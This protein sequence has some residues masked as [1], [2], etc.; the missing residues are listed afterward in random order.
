ML[1]KK[2]ALSERF[3]FRII[4]SLT[5]PLGYNKQF[6]TLQ[7][8]SG[9]IFSLFPVLHWK[10]ISLFI[11]SSPWFQWKYMKMTFLKCLHIWYGQHSRLGMLQDVA[12]DYI[13]FLQLPGRL[14]EP[15]ALGITG[16]F[17]WHHLFSPPRQMSSCISAPTPT[18]RHW[19]PETRV[20][21][22]SFYLFLPPEKGRR[23]IWKTAIAF[24]H[25]GT[26]VPQSFLSRGYWWPFLPW[27]ACIVRK[28][29]HWK[30][31]PYG[32]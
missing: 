17:H 15:T 28:K 3:F 31:C 7:A 11:V 10:I 22:R 30:M 18:P 2:V 27:K 16:P 9:V 26:A 14:D 29:T 25:S 6:F 1:I 32:T 20:G 21:R 5:P 24:T 4:C 23:P 8:C 12:I 19:L 13:Q